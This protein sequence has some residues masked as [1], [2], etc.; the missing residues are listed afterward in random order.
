MIHDD[1]FLVEVKNEI[2]KMIDE[3]AD[4]MGIDTSYYEFK[5]TCN[6]LTEDYEKLSSFVLYEMKN[7]SF[8]TFCGTETYYYDSKKQMH[9]CAGCCGKL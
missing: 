7:Q 8:C 4:K 6:T 3:I 9:L 5:L 2:E 1:E